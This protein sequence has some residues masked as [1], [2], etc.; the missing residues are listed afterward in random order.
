MRLIKGTDSEGFYAWWYIL[1][2]KQKVSKFEEDFSADKNIKLTEYGKVINS[3]YG[4][5]PE[6]EIK[7][8][9]QEEYN[10][11]EAA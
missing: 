2:D 9:M 10:F 8:Q 7:E 4:L 1:L 5:E 6:D 3:G 11:I